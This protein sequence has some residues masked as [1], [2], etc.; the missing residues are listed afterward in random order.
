MCAFLNPK[1][2]RPVSGY[3]G[4]SFIGNRG[5][6]L[7]ECLNK[8]QKIHGRFAT[9]TV[10]GFSFTRL[11]T[12]PPIP[13]S[14]V[15]LSPPLGAQYFYRIPIQPFFF[16]LQ[17]MKH[18]KITVWRLPSQ[19]CQNYTKNPRYSSH[20]NNAIHHTHDVQL[21]HPNIL[22]QLECSICYSF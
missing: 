15:V 11:C 17:R 14:V 21:V 8:G 20:C 18:T 7:I 10:I 13:N 22:N 12:T 16:Y 9:D 19:F 2:Q 5:A 4:E 1:K 6:M 3:I